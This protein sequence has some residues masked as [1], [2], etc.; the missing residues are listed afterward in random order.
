M[1][2]ARIR[3]AVGGILAAMLLCQMLTA[4]ASC[5]SAEGSSPVTAITSVQLKSSGDRLT[6]SATLSEADAAVYKNGTVC[7]FGLEP[8]ET[9]EMVENG[10][11]LPIA[12]SRGAESMRFTVDFGLSD[13][14]RNRLCQ[15]FLLAS[16]DEN[17]VYSVISDGVYL[18]NP[19]VLAV[20]SSTVGA[21]SLKGVT[22]SLGSDVTEL[23]PSHT[24]ID[25]PI[26]EYLCAAPKKGETISYL[27]AGET[28]SIS[29]SAVELLDE[30]V[31][32]LSAQRTA[33]YLR[34]ILQ[35]SPDELPGLSSVGFVGSGEASLYALNLTNEDGYFYIAAFFSFLA[36]RYK[37]IS[38]V[39]LGYS[40]NDADFASSTCTDFSDAVENTLL[41]MRTAYNIFRSANSSVRVYLPVSNLYTTDETLGMT[42]SG[43]REFIAAF[44]SYA[45]VSGD[46]DWSIYLSME[47]PNG[48]STLYL[49]NGTVNDGSVTRKY[50]LPQTMQGLLDLLSADDFLYG[51]AQRDII[52]GVRVSGSESTA[53]ENQQISLL[54][55]YMKALGHNAERT[56]KTALIRAVVWES[57]CDS[58]EQTD[59]LYAADGR[60][61]PAGELFSQLGNAELSSLLDLARIEAK[62]GTRYS[63][64]SAV[65]D[66]NTERGQLYSGSM[67]G[68]DAIPQA[69]SETLLYGK[70]AGWYGAFLPLT[71]SGV[72]S[73]T[74]LHY[75]ESPM[76]YAT[77]ES[78][79]G[80]GIYTGTV[81]ASRLKGQNMLLVRIAAALP[82]GQSNASVRVILQSTSGSSSSRYIGVGSVSDGDWTALV[83][84]IAD[85]AEKLDSNDSLT[86]TLMLSD[87]GASAEKNVSFYLSEIA[88][89][90]T[91]TWISR[92]GWVLFLVLI[93]VVA[94]VVF[95]SIFFHFNELYLVPA[96]AYSTS[97]A[98]GKPSVGAQIL[99]LWYRSVG[100]IR[101]RSRK[102][103]RVMTRPNARVMTR[104]NTVAPH[105]ASAPKYRPESQE[106]NRPHG[107]NSGRGT[108]PRT[109]NPSAAQNIPRAQ[110]PNPYRQPPRNQDPKDIRARDRNK[111]G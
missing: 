111:N 23:A 100:R 57:L 89:Y 65:L 2:Y 50:L 70:T 90:E 63:E 46:F 39:I 48:S 15:R 101:I 97:A 88:V 7:L 78:D 14:L 68:I 38:G 17:D 59:G 108:A 30:M 54:Y 85:Y 56:A 84:D 49:E 98:Q 6:V 24:V 47:V 12:E 45:K 104:D 77:F 96:P 62:L 8:F 26:E 27:Y 74:R 20:T 58:D 33:I 5:A 72:I 93:L 76:L 61:K 40:L 52:W 87:T 66:K 99:A 64:I 9:E 21:S 29:E 82:N 73:L 103:E 31:K 28:L 18:S 81:P 41:L 80:C 60:L 91:N 10:E 55:T 1:K 109:Q 13:G 107:Q 79:A 67:E 32:T 42:E 43:S 75:S 11:L 19:E 16:R 22:V 4:L 37:G 83:F 95:L 71:G 3:R 92:G 105:G 94:G 36:S 106:S 34:P 51:N 25:L 44:A 102:Q 35:T 110:S 69:S 53:E 86:L